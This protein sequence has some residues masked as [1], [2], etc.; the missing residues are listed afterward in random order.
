M[1]KCI[2]CNSGEVESLSW[3]DLN[4]GEQQ[5][6]EVGEFY[7]R[8]CGSH[9]EVAFDSGEGLDEETMP[10]KNQIYDEDESA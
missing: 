3:V 7:C 5:D 6:G 2:K 10:R 4:T 9:T 8:S 1:Y